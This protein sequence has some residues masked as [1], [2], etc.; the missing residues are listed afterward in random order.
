MAM[1][2]GKAEV[3]NMTDNVDDFSVAELRTDGPTDQKETKWSNND[4]N[5]WNGYVHKTPLKSIIYTK[6][7]WIIGKGVKAPPKD[8][9]IMDKW[10]GWGKDTKNA[11]IKN[12]VMTAYT[13]GDGFGEIIR[14][15]S[16]FRKIF[17]WFGI[18]KPGKPVNLKPLDPSVIDTIVNPQGMLLRYEQHAKTGKK[19]APII[20]KP[21]NMFHLAKDRF[22]DNIH[23][24][25]IVPAIENIILSRGESMSDMKTVFHRYVKPLW[26]W[27]LD[28]DKESKIREF[29][30]KADRTVA[31]S[32]NIYIPRGAVEA[33]RM[34]VPQYSTLDPLP[35]IEYLND[36]L[37]QETN[38]PD[39]ITGSA[40][41]TVE[42]SAK[43]LMLAF[44]QSV[45]DD[46][47]WVM[48]NFKSQ[49]G[50]D[51]TLEFPTPIEADLIRDNSKDGNSNF[52]KSDTRTG[53]KG[54]K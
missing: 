23:G 4:F 54:E 42:A 12:L 17:M 32:E 18:L 40:K 30:A 33:E 9:A 52:K 31:N 24:T 53:I 14:D 43:I 46:Q 41:Q 16:I 51:I 50:L 21:E 22:A 2:I 35:W 1:D 48:E 19:D 37:N 34:S 27:Q 47:L 8:M 5:Q 39:I 28:T 25:S 49:L 45:R 7:R 44:E 26:I 38:T 10:R 13:G 15:D 6:A 36:N 20:I 11:I 29:K 3:G